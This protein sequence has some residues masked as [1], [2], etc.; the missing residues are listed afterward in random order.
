M[1]DKKDY[2][3]VLGLKKG[4][5]EEEIK[6]AFRKMAMKYHPDRNP[7]DASAEEKFKEV[8]EAYSVL[9]D[10]DKKAKYDRFGFAGIDPS[11]GAGSYSGGY[12]GPSGFSGFNASDFGFDDLGD[13]FNMFTGG[14]SSYSS[15][16]NGPRKGADIQKRMTISFEE[17]AFGVKKTISVTKDCECEACKGTGAKGGTAKHTCPQCNGTGTATTVQNTILGTMR[18]TGTCNVCNGKG[19][20]IDTKCDKCYGSGSVN[21]TVSINVDIPAGVDTNSVITLR[22]QGEPG[23]KGGSAG[24]L[25]IVLT[26]AAHDYLKRKGN[27][28]WITVPITFTQAALGD[29]ITIPSLR[30][31]ISCKIPAGTQPGTVLRVKGKGIAALNTGKMGDMYVEVNL[32]VPTKLTAKQKELIREFGETKP[33]EGSYAKRK[34]FA[35]KVKE[36]FD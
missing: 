28:L 32:E 25:Y 21:K 33:A 16:R 9:S 5:S 15:T 18:R 36:F 31:K 12:T 3:E 20:I 35:D 4:A 14:G 30:E 23:T 24:D 26:V 29:E 19:Y 6:S 10:P 13:I 34:S 11:Y 22:G 8:N 27:D 1:A 17:A 7:G 2:Y